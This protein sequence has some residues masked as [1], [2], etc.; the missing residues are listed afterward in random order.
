MR[1]QRVLARA[2]L[3]SRRQA[4]TLIAAGRVLVN[5]KPA[6]LGQTVDPA[7]DNVTLDGAP[8]KGPVAAQWL[9][10]Y[11][12][13]GV[14]TTRCDPQGRPTVFGLVPEI[15]GLTYVG[16]L[17][18]MTEGVL[19]FTTDGEAAHRLTHPSH[20]VERTYVAVVRGNAAAAVRQARKG[21]ELEDGFVRPADVQSRPIGDRR[22]EFEITL[23][24]GRT[25]EV[26]RLCEAL[27]LEVERLVRIRFGPVRL[28]ALTPGK[29]RALNA[30][31]L[32]VIEAL[33]QAAPKERVEADPW[34]F[35]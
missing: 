34:D 35:E 14:L 30:T 4:E 19:L 24:E 33:V 29:S 12:P 7:R 18:Y 2:G 31:E 20:E 5:G 25:R 28:T 15:P 17:D 16:R 26:R 13:A 9:V 10:L 3:S 11:K 27:G 1:L 21:V 32:R 8:V 22:Y 6:Q 23:T